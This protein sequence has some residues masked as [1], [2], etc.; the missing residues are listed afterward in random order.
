MKAEE[1]ANELANRFVFESPLKLNDEEL[2]IERER[3]RKSAIIC[4]EEMQK[5]CCGLENWNFL[6]DMKCEVENL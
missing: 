4:I 2:L 3:A 5:V 1:K 6:E